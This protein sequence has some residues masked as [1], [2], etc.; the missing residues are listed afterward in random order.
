MG[1]ASEDW[2][3]WSGGV[4]GSVGGCG[5]GCCI[6]LLMHKSCFD[7]TVLAQHCCEY[8]TRKFCHTTSGSSLRA[9]IKV[10]PIPHCLPYSL[11][12]R[13]LLR[14]IDD[15]AGQGILVFT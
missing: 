5:G 12:R 15:P 2:E 3:W 14:R 1:V 4:C 7:K 11:N 10:D 6:R 13:H 8:R 9:G